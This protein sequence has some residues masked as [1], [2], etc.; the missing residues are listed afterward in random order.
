MVRFCTRARA[1]SRFATASWSSFDSGFPVAFAVGFVTPPLGC[2]AQDQSVLMSPLHASLMLQSAMAEA[3][4]F[5]EAVRA[6]LTFKAAAAAA[7]A[8]AAIPPT[9]RAPP[10]VPVLGMAWP[11]T[12]D[13]ARCFSLM[14]ATFRAGALPAAGEAVLP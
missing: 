10:T 1:A 9:P 6:A 5:T 7:A 2:N 14:R 11:P 12:E 8:T 4:Q 3:T 13:M